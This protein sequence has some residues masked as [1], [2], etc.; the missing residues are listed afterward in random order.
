MEH[1]VFLFADVTFCPQLD[2]TT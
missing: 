2:N 1:P